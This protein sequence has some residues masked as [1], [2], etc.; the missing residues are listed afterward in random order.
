MSRSKA[1]N[2]SRYYHFSLSRNEALRKSPSLL[3]RLISWKSN[4]L[5]G[6]DRP[7]LF[8]EG[9][10]ADS[11]GAPKPFPPDDSPGREGTLEGHPPYPKG[12][13]KRSPS[14]RTAPGC[15]RRAPPRSRSRDGQPGRRT[16]P[17]EDS[18]RS[19]A[20]RAPART[21]GSQPRRCAPQGTR[22]APAPRTAPPPGRRPPEAEAGWRTYLGGGPQRSLRPVT[23][24]GGRGQLPAVEHGRRHF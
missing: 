21:P 13:R 11:A 6:A 14:A 18:G 9:R 10:Q 5:I 1:T 4:S 19:G 17:P 20:A 23:P 3:S 16:G 22:D 7:R 2:R 15:S 12:A 24:Q 8:V